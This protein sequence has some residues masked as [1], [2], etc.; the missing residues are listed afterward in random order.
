[1]SENKSD[2]LLIKN[3][4][5]IKSSAGVRVG[6]GKDPRYYKVGNVDFVDHY[7]KPNGNHQLIDN[8]NDKLSYTCG[9]ADETK[10]EYTGIDAYDYFVS[11]DTLNNLRTDDKKPHKEGVPI[12]FL[13]IDNEIDGIEWYRKHYPKLPDELLPVIARYN[14]GEPI[15]K[16]AVK[17]E[18]KKFNKK[19]NKEN[20]KLIRKTG[21]FI[22]EFN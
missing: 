19:L 18:R 1:M 8:R 22:V 4:F 21:N 5:T 2:P 15:T 6:V 17:N 9:K 11:A 20:N 14:W 3:P 16:K 10:Q 7:K 13:Q 12:S